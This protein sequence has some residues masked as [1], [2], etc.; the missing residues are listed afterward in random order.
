VMDGTPLTELFTPS[1]T[2]EHTTTRRPLSTLTASDRGEGGSDRD[3]DAVQERLEDL[4][5]I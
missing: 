1:F 5:Y 3:A 4:G 2:D